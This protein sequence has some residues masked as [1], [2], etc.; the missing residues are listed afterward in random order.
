MWL[1]AEQQ[2][3]RPSHLAAA[4]RWRALFRVGTDQEAGKKAVIVL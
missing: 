4:S 3:E 2:P 1:F